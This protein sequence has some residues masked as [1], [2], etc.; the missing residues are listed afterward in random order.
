M[1]VEKIGNQ[2]VALML[3]AERTSDLAAAE[4]A[5]L[6][7]ETAFSRLRD[8]RRELWAPYYEV[9]LTKAREIRDRLKGK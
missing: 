4:T 3:I 2:G 1:G 9:Q 7:I 6:Q 8:G 5:V